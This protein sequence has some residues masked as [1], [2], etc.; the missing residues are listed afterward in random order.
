MSILIILIVTA[1]LLVWSKITLKSYINLTESTIL[2]EG[3]GGEGRGLCQVSFR[4]FSSTKVVRIHL[5]LWLNKL[6]SVHFFLP[7]KKLELKL[8]L[9]LF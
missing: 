2:R 4:L 5:L 8:F 9:I 7:L 1:E 6:H 3:P